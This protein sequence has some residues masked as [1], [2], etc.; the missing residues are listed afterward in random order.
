[1]AQ[2]KVGVWI[3]GAL[4]SIASTLLAGALAMRQGV[5]DSR[6]M[7]TTTEP[8]ARIGLADVGSMEF[9]GCDVRQGSLKN[10]VCE[11]LTT[12]G[13]MQGV[14]LHRFEEDLARIER[15]IRPGTLRNCGQAIRALGSDPVDSCLSLR[16][17]IATIISYLDEFR[18][19][20]DL[21]E[22]VV[23][24]LA[25][26]E[27][28]LQLDD[29][30]Q[31]LQAFESQLD[32]NGDGAVRAGTIYAYAAITCGCPYINF[33]PSNG[34]LF[35]AMVQLAEAHGVPVMGNDGKTGETL[36]KS[37]LAPMFTC[38]DL[39]V[40]SWEGFNILGNLDGRI[41][42]N[43][44]NR[45]S[46][47]TTKDK[48]LPQ[49]LGY[50]PHTSVH[51]DYVPSLS[52]QKTAWDFIH[53]RGFLGA[54]MSLQF[55]WQGYDSL[56]AAPLVLDLVRLAD[57]AKM[58]GESGLMRHLACFFKDPLE[59]DEHGLYEQFQLLLEYASRAA[60]GSSSAVTK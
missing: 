59:V 47:I 30:H 49:I 16:E 4:G 2:R 48:V 36:I 51:I 42:D 54:K 53:F 9:S 52:D 44:E 14:D 19:D 31:N 20:F 45:E 41:L 56:L 24:N 1:M 29:F 35:P 50:A 33:T 60:G 55:V 8:F 22:V 38:R 37:A 28:M 13:T 25:S 11:V 6:G 10:S 17:E 32:I 58:R 39:E 26:T 15:S 21:D 7:V 46:K 34:A 27:P 18:S 5:A 40:L 3:V 12:T 23:V 43:P 57:L